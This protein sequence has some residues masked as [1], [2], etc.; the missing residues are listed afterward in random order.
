[1]TPG[2]GPIITQCTSIL[3]NIDRTGH[4]MEKYRFVTDSSEPNSTRIDTMWV[5]QKDYNYINVEFAALYATPE[6]IVLPK[7]VTEF[8][9]GI[10]SGKIQINL[11]KVDRKDPNHPFVSQNETQNCRYQPRSSNPNDDIFH[12]NF[13]DENFDRLLE[14]G[15][16]LTLTVIAENGGF[17]KLKTPYGYTNDY[18]NGQTSTKSTMFRFDF[19][20]PH[21]CLLDKP[22]PC[23][24]KAFDITEDITKSPIRLY[25]NGW[26]DKLSGIKGYKLQVFLLKSN[27]TTLKEPRPWN[28]DEEISLNKSESG[29]TYFPKQSGMFSFILNVIDNANNTQYAR[30][31]VLYDPKS[32]VTLSSSQFFATTAEQETNYRW[33]KNLNSN[34]SMSWKGH[35]QN[36]FHHDEGLLNPVAR[37]LHYDFMTKYEKQVPLELD[38]NTGNRSLQRIPNVFGIVKFEY[39]YRNSNQGNKTPI[40]WK[41]VSEPLSENQTFNIERRDGDTINFWV[42]ATDILGN[43]KIDMTQISFDSSPPSKLRDADVT[44]L[45][46]VKTTN[47]NFSSRLQ[48][49]AY[50]KDSGIHKIKWELIANNSNMVFRSGEIP[51]NKTN[52]E[53]GPK[54]GYQ[55]PLGDTYYYT[56]YLDINNCWMVVSKEKFATEFVLL[57]LTVFNMAMEQTLYNM[58]IT[59]LA[60]LDGMD[61]YSGPINLT[62]AATYDNSVRL[63]WVL[64]PT[65]YERTTIIVKSLSING[66]VLSWN[67]DRNADWF[68]LTGLDPETNYN[69]SFI[70][71]YGSQTSDPVVLQFRTIASPAALTG[72]AIAGISFAFLILLGIIVAMVVLWRLGR[73]SVIKQDIQR[74]A[75]V[76]RKNIVNRFSAAHIN[77]T[78]E[79]DDIYLYGQMD[80]NEK[81]NKFLWSS[82]IVLDAML[83]SGR[84]ADIYKAR[85]LPHNNKAKQNVIAKTLKSGYSEEDLLMMKAKI[86]FFAKEVGDHPNIIGFIGAVADNDAFGPYMVLEYCQN[87]QLRDWLLQQKNTSTEETVELLYRISYGISK[88]MYFLETKKLLHRRLAA[89]NVLLNAELEPKIS[90]FGPEPPQPQNNERDGDAEEKERIPVKWT[91][92]ECLSSMKYATTKSDVWSFGIVLWEIF[93]LGDTPYPGI[94]SRDLISLVKN[95]ERMKRPEF[96][97]DFYYGV[98][99]KCWR[100]KPNQRPSFK[101]ISMD[102]GKTFNAAPSDEFYYYSEK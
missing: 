12:C 102:I 49:D 63:K 17:R 50:D 74:R 97:N 92:P 59:D 34:I 79:C 75:T 78:Y 28:P 36:K 82:D 1:M 67:V 77:E 24:S 13:T 48:V 73:L 80:F 45:R 100:S 64:P 55:I 27:T 32:N 83:T 68:D 46:N 65:C 87:G 22:I 93:S 41:S 10:V 54:L 96:A 40:F 94:R 60:S 29:Y 9:F 14:N 5:N 53:L 30:T 21:H 35:F 8:K 98:M 44:F 37:Y 18:F 19:I 57:K 56:H 38:D 101:D 95:G 61:E 43:D 72:G 16:N 51:G 11:Q 2:N 4:K 81:D 52:K 33:Q 70:T 84:F 66:R 85:Y 3:A 20:K 47:F 76:V 42:K 6:N 90:G 62:I 25:W 15:D 69:L 7:Y 88:G 58:T 99:A 71:K 39:F 86:N 89:R 31:L 91:A 26:I 23:S